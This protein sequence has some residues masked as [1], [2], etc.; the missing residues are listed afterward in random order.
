MRKHLRPVVPALCLILA[1]PPAPAQRGADWVTVGFDAHRSHWVRNDA[2]I[3]VAS[4]GKPGFALVWKLKLAPAPRQL[5]SV[6]PPALLDFYISH[7]GFRT[8]GF[9]GTASNRVVGVDTDLGRIEWEKQVAPAPPA[10]GATLPCPGGMTAPVT[11]PA[12]L[13]YPPVPTGR[14]AARASAP[15][16][17][18]GEPFK[19]AVTIKPFPTTP[20]P[21]PPAPAKGAPPSPFEPH[22]EPVYSLASDGKLRTHYVSN[23]DE[24]TPGIAFLP[25]NAHAVGL[26]AASGV[27]YVATVNNCGGIDNGIW[28]LDLKTQKVTRW[29]TTNNIAGTD[30]L[31]IGPDGTI[32][33]AAGPELVA[34]TPGVLEPKAVYKSDAGD[35]AS[36]P[37]VFDYQGRNLLV[38]KNKQGRLQIFDTASL[39]A[40]LASADAA[41]GESGALATWQDPSGTRWFHAPAGNVIQSWK[42]AGK[43]AA[44]TLEKAWTSRELVSPLPP[45]VVN[46]VVF[47]LSSGEHRPAT[48][49]VSAAL[50]ARRSVPAVLYALDAQTG[51]ELWNSGKTIPTFVH[52]GGLAAGGTRVYVGAYDGTQYAFGFPIEH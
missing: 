13:A 7:R 42:L 14:P 50:R 34:L 37:A 46:G 12:P 48:P 25:P 33:A 41:A 16:S 3:S 18:V 5:N 11:R 32:Y 6:T 27:A 24:P 22:L 44:L 29:K 40:P 9:F 20:P 35:F 4:L 43:D 15:K 38:V 1:I 45:I 47:A 30:G 51:A 39:K 31:A 8:L 28:A 21:P 2:K 10:A 23:G 49:G 36:T 17:A 19:G 26:I 52:S